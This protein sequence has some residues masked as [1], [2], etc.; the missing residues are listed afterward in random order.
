MKRLL[1]GLAYD[2]RED[3]LKEGF[4][5]EETAEFDRDDT[6]EALEA[7]LKRRGHDTDRI[8]HGRQLVHRLAQGDRWDLVFNIAEGLYGIGREA[9]VPALLDAYRIPY[10]FSD[11]L[12]LALTLHKGMTKQIVRALGIPT[13]DFV[14][15]SSPED[16][17]GIDLP[18]P[19]FAK[20]VAE[21]TG[22]GIS[23]LSKISSQAE[24]KEV[25]L[26]LLT[27]F[28]QPVLVET[29]LP[30][31]EFTAGM[32]GTDSKSRCIGV[33]EVVFK[34]VMDR[35]RIYSYH[36]K[37]NYEDIVHYRI[38]E[39]EVLEQ[40][41][42]LALRAWR[43]LG[44]RDGGRIDIRMDASGVPN[45]IEVNPLAGLNP[46]H[47]DLPIICSLSGIPYQQLIDEIME[48]A[49]NRLEPKRKVT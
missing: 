18:L 37:A 16:I 6:I 34:E 31:R 49:L 14:V 36:T 11:P 33:M 47:S 39:P 30:G 12:V 20:P 7:C 32:V 1:I 15:V 38:P 43:G 4:S 26:H 29:Y 48:S 27:E 22:K 45:F 21:G 40:C 19:L 44:C 9:L 24:L 17:D 46:V 10:T 3:Y 41:R 28:D 2:L 42:D 8:G 35:D 25:C 23:A 5:L 13:A